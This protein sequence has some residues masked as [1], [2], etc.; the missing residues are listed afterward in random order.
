MSNAPFLMY[1]VV[2]AACTSRIRG[3]DRK[4]NITE[5][6]IEVERDGIHERSIEQWKGFIGKIN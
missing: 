5:I 4:V 1:S 6:G 2:A 3:K